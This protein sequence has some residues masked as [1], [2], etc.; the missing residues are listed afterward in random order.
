MGFK[1]GDK[2]ECTVTRRTTGNHK[3]L[4]EKGTII[5]IRNLGDYYIFA[6]EFDNNVSGHNCEGLG[7]HGHCYWLREEYLKLVETESTTTTEPQL[8]NY[9]IKSDQGKPRLSLVP[10]NGIW[11]AI[12]K[13]REYGVKKYTDTESWKQVEIQ[14]Y[15]DAVLRH[16][17][18]CTVDMDAVDEESGML[19]RWHVECNLAFIEELKGMD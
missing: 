16:I 7:K 17:A 19:H 14:R 8:T 6:V 18:A 13:I 1:V 11:T 9:D 2:V 3:L 12:S 10:I 5:K 4:G 15:W